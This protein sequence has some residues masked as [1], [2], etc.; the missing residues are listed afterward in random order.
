IKKERINGSPSGKVEGHGDR[1]APEHTDTIGSKEKKVTKAL[2]FYKM[3]TEEV[4]EQYI[5]P[6][7]VSVLD[8]YDGE[9]NLAL[10]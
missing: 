3:E 1:D 6:R 2:S 4:S 10:D 7:F 8:A 5:V 9:I